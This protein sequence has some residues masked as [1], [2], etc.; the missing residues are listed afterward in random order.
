MKTTN[1]M[2]FSNG[3][4]FMI[5]QSNNCAQCPQYENTSTKRNKAKC[6]YAFDIDLAQGT[7]ELPIETINYFG[8]D[9]NYNLANCPRLHCGRISDYNDYQKKLKEI[10]KNKK[11]ELP[12]N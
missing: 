2:P 5:W 7:E 12:F 11:N 1:K 8:Y 10:E 9:K 3:T 6:K 4:D